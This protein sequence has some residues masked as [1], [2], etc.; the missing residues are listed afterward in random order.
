MKDQG[1]GPGPLLSLLP[2]WLRS[3]GHPCLLIS[4]PQIL[5]CWCPRLLLDVHLLNWWVFSKNSVLV[6]KKRPR[7]KNPNIN[8]ATYRRQWGRSEAA[9]CNLGNV[10]LSGWLDSLR[11]Y[12]LSLRHDDWMLLLLQPPIFMLITCS[13]TSRAHTRL[14]L[15][16][17][18]LMSC[19]RLR[20]DGFKSEKKELY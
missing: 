16:V 2:R 9:G 10:F 12:C 7:G 11:N 8:A 20:W 13:V 19:H 17:L 3:S 14:K 1:A 4:H 15:T 18:T 6:G 5:M